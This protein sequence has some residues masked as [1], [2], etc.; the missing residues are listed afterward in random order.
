MFIKNR[1]LRVFKQENILWVSSVLALLSFLAFLVSGLL[2]VKMI[3]IFIFGLNLTGIFALTVA[4]AMDRD[5]KNTGILSS[6][7]FSS[8]YF[9]NIVFHYSIGYFSER[10]SV[11]IIPIVEIIALV[12]MAVLAV[13][14][15]F[16]LRR[17]AQN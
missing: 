9:A 7:I 1:L 15:F 17:P 6:L 13:T 14:I 4:I 10:I 5:A 2:V 11:R 16:L 8:G 3:F 12:L